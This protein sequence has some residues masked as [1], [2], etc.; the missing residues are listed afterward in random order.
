MGG[1][2]AAFS[3]S[4]LYFLDC[5][6]VSNAPRDLKRL[7][8]N[9]HTNVVSSSTSCGDPDDSAFVA[10]GADS[11]RT[12]GTAAT[13]FAAAARRIAE[14]AENAAAA[15]KLRDPGSM[16]IL[17]C[18][19]SPLALSLSSSATP[20]DLA[21]SEVERNLW[22]GKQIH[23]KVSF[24]TSNSVAYSLTPDGQQPTVDLG[25][26]GRRHALACQQ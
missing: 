20:R 10:A 14:G 8:E 24:H 18:V 23:V 17:R 25:G 13:G 21:R 4:D 26:N 1:A 2:A 15:F 3:A 19:A 22:S 6:Y 16:K 7:P 12:V 9:G 11:S 5:L